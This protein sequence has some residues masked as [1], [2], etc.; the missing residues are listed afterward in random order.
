MVVNLRSISGHFF[1]FS[2]LLVF[3][4]SFVSIVY[5]PLFMFSYRSVLV[6]RSPVGLS[7]SDY[8]RIRFEAREQPV[9]PPLNSGSSNKLM[10]YA[11][12]VRN[13]ITVSS[14]A[15]TSP[16]ASDNANKKYGEFCKLSISRQTVLIRDRLQVIRRLQEKLSQLKNHLTYLGRLQRTCLV[17]NGC[18]TLEVG[19]F[20]TKKLIGETKTEIDSLSR[21]LDLIACE[22]P[23]RSDSMFFY[24]VGDSN[25]VFLLI[26][27]CCYISYFVLL[28][29]F[30]YLARS[31][32]S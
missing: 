19:L 8:E 10:V 24:P 17:P 23:D 22:D 3:F 14:I 12:A 28:I 5:G 18:D 21:Q 31:N 13:R 32:D 11:D 7:D 27:L 20:Y 26:V 25:R 16:E 2:S 15:R 6:M 29:I 4:V 30:R 1:L 9:N